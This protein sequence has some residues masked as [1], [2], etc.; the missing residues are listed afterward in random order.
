MNDF[1]KSLRSGKKDKRFDKNRKPYNP[2]YNNNYPG[3]YRGEKNG[4]L[5]KTNFKGIEE[6]LEEIR[7][8]L[9]QI[10]KNSEQRV[11][12]EKRKAKAM[13]DLAIVLRIY[14]NLPLPPVE[15]EP[16]EDLPVSELISAPE[17]LETPETLEAQEDMETLED[18]EAQEYMETQEIDN[19]EPSIA[20]AEKK[21]EI[22]P[23]ARSVKSARAAKKEN[24]QKVLDIITTMRDNGSTYNEI[25]MHL[26]SQNI[27]TFSRKG[28]WHAQTIHR[29]CRSLENK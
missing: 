13:E 25:A 14:L 15:E 3:G 11:I 9:A 24:R 16:V 8:V 10:A 21:E 29:V 18:M 1:L 22:K 26:E 7:P 27:P 12:V 28:K 4:N 19:E 17:T 5:K 2:N 20:A 23:S 6:S